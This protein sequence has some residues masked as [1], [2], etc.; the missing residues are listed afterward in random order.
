MEELKPKLPTEQEWDPITIRNRT[1][2]LKS[3]RRR[4]V[5]AVGIGTTLAV[6]L[7]GGAIV[8][9]LHSKG[10]RKPAI[11]PTTLTTTT[12]TRPETTTTIAHN[13]RH[14]ETVPLSNG[15]D[16][17]CYIARISVAP[18]TSIDLYIEFLDHADSMSQQH[19][20]E[21]ATI[22]INERAGLVH[23]PN[24]IEVKQQLELATDCVI[25]QSH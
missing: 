8:G 7:G 15:T 14:K 17:S 19:T 1:N 11:V 20:D 6:A 2:R 9:G 23:N 21:A 5:V 3:E 10:K 22:D 13:T 4:K 25:V 24:V 16:A 18:H 12:T